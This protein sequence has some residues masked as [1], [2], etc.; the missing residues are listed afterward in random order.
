MYDVTYSKQEA[1]ISYSYNNRLKIPVFIFHFNVYIS[2]NILKNKSME[3]TSGRK[4][5]HNVPREFKT[6]LY[7]IFKKTLFCSDFG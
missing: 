5:E 7:C 1:K 6:K 2:I 4:C 3:I